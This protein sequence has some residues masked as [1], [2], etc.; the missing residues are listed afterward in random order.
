MKKTRIYAVI[1]LL[2]AVG[3]AYFNY[4]SEFNPVNDSPLAKAFPQLAVQRST[5]T[6]TQASFIQGF[7]L[8]FGLDLRGGSHLVY[9]ADI[10]KIRKELKWLPKTDLKTGILETLETEGWKKLV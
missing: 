2:L 5:A 6:T 4:H 1:A 7:P 10:S 9:K 3:L 8:K